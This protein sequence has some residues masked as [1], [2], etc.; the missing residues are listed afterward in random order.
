M[1]LM[2]QSGSVIL[3]DWVYEDLAVNEHWMQPGHL[4]Q[5]T[6]GPYEPAVTP[7]QI[8]NQLAR[9]STVIESGNPPTPRRR[10]VIATTEDGGANH[11]VAEQAM[12]GTVS[13]YWEQQASRSLYLG[14]CIFDPA[15][16]HRGIGYRALGL[17]TQYL[18]DELP[19]I[20]RLGLRT[21]SGNVGMVRLAKKL[22]YQE[23]MRLRQA[24]IVK[25]EYFDGMG[26]GLLRTEWNAGYPDGFVE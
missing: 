12:I 21:W 24:R 11:R 5:E 22:G 14:I 20:V 16:W 15:N 10:L 18:F 2:L 3:R 1:N 13:A 25:G 9:I 8:E 7:L 26:Y 23:E 4:W 17:W 6:D 19:D